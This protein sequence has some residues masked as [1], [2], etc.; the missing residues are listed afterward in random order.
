MMRKLARLLAFS[1][2]VFTGNAYA[3]PFTE[4]P[5]EAFLIQDTVAKAY[6]VRLGT[7]YYQLLADD[8]NTNNRLNGVGFSVHDDYIYGWNY[9]TRSPGRMGSDYQIEAL[10]TNGLPNSDFYV[11]DVSVVDN[12]YFVYRPGAAFGLYRIDLSTSTP[13]TA[14]QIID[15][16]SLNIR[17]FDM[18]FHPDDGFAYA[19]DRN[20]LLWQMNVTNGDAT[21]LGN[22]GTSGTFGAAYFD[23][24]GTMYVSR[25]T[26]GHI[27]RI[28][29]DSSEPIAELFALGPASSNNDG[30]RCALAP[31]TSAA[32]ST[33]D[34]GDAPASYGTY[35]ADNGARHDQTNNELFLGAAV[36]SEADAWLYPES[37]DASSTSDGNGIDDEDGVAFV[38]GLEVGQ[39][40]I[41][42]INASQAGFVN[43]WIDLD[44]NGQFDDEEKLLDGYALDAGDNPV[45]MYIPLWASLGETWARVRLSSE[46]TL[47]PTGG[48]ADGEVEDYLIT[49]TSADLEIVHYP[50]Q[51]G[52][53]TLAFEDTWPLQGDYDM[54][55][56]VVHQRITHYRSK[57][58]DTLVGV[59]IQGQIAALGASYH[60]GFAVRL[61][62]VQRTNIGEANVRFDNNFGATGSP[63]EANRN[64][65]IVIVANDLW[66]HISAGEGC[67]FYRTSADCGGPAQM[68]YDLY[69]PTTGVSADTTAELSLGLDPFIFATPGATRPGV[70][71]GSPGR[72][73]EIHLKNQE[74]TEAFDLSF[75]GQNDD[76]S[77]GAAYFLNQKGMPW[78][79]EISERWAHPLS[80]ID[81]VDAYPMFIDFVQ[82]NGT[83]ESD[84][85]SADKAITSN[86][87]V[88]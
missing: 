11:G 45:A 14:E 59:R 42:S 20:G 39:N 88:E 70:F 40:S 24:N 80:G 64:E 35:L 52:W 76:A 27:Y 83:A 72:G 82:S 26:D 23:V 66:Q 3:E 61:P 19:V 16:A 86:T 34:F 31:I 22:V 7:G 8:L 49:I 69:L 44:N 25:N 4:C 71:G 9:A 79:L 77:E 10:P 68:V 13:F 57:S 47:P 54:N 56:V 28:D 67:E 85:Y 12:A 63:L 33:I 15:G 46:G 50:S 58:N 2:L 87:F 37:D 78:A 43:V 32:A 62:G 75:L 48:A 5:I 73:L 6:G 29:I 74:P 18:A 38:T 81:L 51:N 84:W 55:D 17:I 1:V 65:A 60:N 53:S 21:S 41:L 36:D 30:A